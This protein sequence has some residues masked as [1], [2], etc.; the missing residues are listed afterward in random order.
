MFAAKNLLLAGGITRVA[1]DNSG[2]DG[3]TGGRSSATV[4]MTVAAGASVI[5]GYASRTSPTVSSVTAGGSA[6]T[7]VGSVLGYAGNT[8]NGGM[9]MYTILN[10]GTGAS[11][12]MVLTLSG[13]ANIVWFAASYTNVSSFGT[14]VTNNGTS[15]SPS[16]TVSSS[17]GHMAFAMF[18]QSSNSTQTGFTQTQRQ[19][20]GGNP[21]LFCGD[22]AGA[23][24]VVFG[25]TYGSSGTKW[26][27][28]GIDMV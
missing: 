13:N 14:A 27:A 22:A 10:I 18:G 21:G 19:N 12:S 26:G 28:F 2:V 23:A 15:A 9:R 11:I 3:T 24:S 7:P 8:A 20:N 5:A 1:Y 25:G 16:V 6:M 17:P 4:T